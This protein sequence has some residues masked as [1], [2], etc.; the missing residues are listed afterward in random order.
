MQV[1]HQLS[2]FNKNYKQKETSFRRD[3]GF[4]ELFPLSDKLVGN[5]PLMQI[6]FSLIDKHSIHNR[7]ILITGE[8]GTGKE[9]VA[10]MLHYKSCRNLKPFVYV[11]CTS[12][13]SSDQECFVYE[14]ETLLRIIES[15][16]KRLINGGT[17]FIS[18][19]SK[20]DLEIQ[21]KF[22]R[23]LKRQETKQTD[24]FSPSAIK[25]I[26]ASGEDLLSAVNSETFLDELYYY[27][28]TYK[29]EVPPLRC[30]KMD[31]PLLVKYHLNKITTQV[32]NRPKKFS[33]EALELLMNYDWPGNIN[34]LNAIIEKAV[35]HHEGDMIYS[36]DLPEIVRK[37]NHF[38][39]LRD[40][41]KKHIKAA[42]RKAYGNKAKAASLL[43][44]S[45]ATIYKKIKEFTDDL[46]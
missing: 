1:T 24:I 29:I 23:F 35:I 39:T 3:K 19:I 32:G 2:F 30:H 36:K 27:L 20:I 16:E 4:V 9:L 14:K 21:E 26:A 25:I 43:N 31:I 42:L 34:E 38:L 11:T 46:S 44:I 45:R 13:F 22:L 33:P 5:S 18:D 12:K 40:I 10:N 15:R 41:E 7:P 8:N 37:K 28:S 6:L 17:V